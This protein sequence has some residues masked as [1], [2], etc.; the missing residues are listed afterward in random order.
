[1][2]KSAL[3]KGGARMPFLHTADSGKRRAKRLRRRLRFRKNLPLFAM[4]A[5]PLCY[6]LVF[7]YVPMSG[8]IMAFQNYRLIDGL[9]GSEWVGLR[10]FSLILHTPNMYRIILN[11]IRLGLLNVL[12]AFPFP[13][14]TAIM[15]SEI[16][17]RRLRRISQTVLYLPHLFSWVI[18]GGMVIACFSQ[19]GPI[20]TLLSVLGMEKKHFLT[21]TVSWTAIHIGAGIYKETG[22]EAIVYLAA[23]T[24]IDPAL[25]E[26]ARVDGASKL[27]QLRHIT[28]PGLRPTAVL[29]LIMAAGKV[30]SV[31]FDQTYILQNAAVYSVSNVISVFSFTSGVR[32]SNYSIATAMELFDSVVSLLLVL[33]A[34]HLAR[35]TEDSLF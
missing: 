20:N 16:Q 23:L 25:Y 14:V 29:M 27:Q 31:S 10:N 4:L 34:N 35:K 22:Y 26:A 21:D 15:L 1:M 9:R 5:L 32:Q 3:M 33:L 17:N 12:I 7:C 28:L 13:I 19:S 30:T 6:Y 11:T 8:L 18:L 24:T 2:R